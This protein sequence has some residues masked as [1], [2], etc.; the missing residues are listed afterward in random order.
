MT[1][2]LNNLICLSVCVLSAVFYPGAGFAQ[3]NPEAADARM[4]SADLIN[5]SWESHGARDIE[6]TFKYTQECIDYYKEDADKQQ[7]ALRALP[8]GKDEID[9]VQALNDV[10]TAYFI[11]AESYMRQEKPD[12]AKKIFQ[13]IIDKYYYAQ[14]WDQRGWYWQ[15]SEASKQSIQ[16]MEKGTIELEKKVKVSQLPTKIDLYDPG[17]EDFVNYEEYGEFVNLG[18]EDYKYVITDQEGLSLAVG[19]GIFP[20]TSS[21]RWD[22]KFKKALKDKRLYGNHWDFVH[23]PDLEAAFFK[24]ATGSEPAGVRLFYTG[25]ILEKSGLIKHALKCY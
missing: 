22:P 16:K 1:L 4:S 7:A 2:R 24:W 17:K 23:S 6:A 18:K 20:N 25:L 12:E 21:V 9:N 19:E 15:I 10:A 3:N 11:Q 14:A 5:K 13:L 8:K